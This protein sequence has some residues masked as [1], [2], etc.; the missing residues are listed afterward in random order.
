MAAP[1]SLPPAFWY[2]ARNVCQS[3]RS[4]FQAGSLPSLRKVAVITPVAFSRPAGASAVPID[5]AIWFRMNT[6][7]QIVLRRDPDHLC[8]IFRE[9]REHEDF[10]VRSLQDRDMTVQMA[11]RDVIG[12]IDADVAGDLAQPFLQSLEEL[13]AEIVVLPEGHDLLAGIEGLDVVGVD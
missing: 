7:R 1:S 2:L 12:N 5:E 10:G 13:A 8:R 9:A 3:L 11:V 4:S 6:G